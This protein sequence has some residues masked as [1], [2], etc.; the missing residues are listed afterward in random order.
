MH[1]AAGL[2]FAPPTLSVSPQLQIFLVDWQGAND[3]RVIIR[4]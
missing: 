4:L 1:T 2:L 3:A